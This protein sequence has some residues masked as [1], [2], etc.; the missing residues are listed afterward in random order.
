MVN[1]R[2]ELCRLGYAYRKMR[3]EPEKNNNNK[4][5]IGELTLSEAASE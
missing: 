3:P 5:I 2:G 4:M 1:S